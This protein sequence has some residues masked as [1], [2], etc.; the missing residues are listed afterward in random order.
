M[1][2]E[3]ESKRKNEEFRC[4]IRRG[5]IEHFFE[6]RRR[7]ILKIQDDEEIKKELNTAA[8]QHE[9]LSGCGLELTGEPNSSWGNCL[10]K[11]RRAS[12]FFTGQFDGWLSVGIVNSLT[13]LFRQ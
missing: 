5:E 12:S 1:Q 2:A 7:E 10:V 8:K 6:E 4:K 3:S 9:F 11:L 13:L